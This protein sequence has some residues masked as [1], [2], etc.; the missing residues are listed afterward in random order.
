MKLTEPKPGADQRESKVLRLPP[1]E[2]TSE[3]ASAVVHSY[4]LLVAYMTSQMAPPFGQTQTKSHLIK[5]NY[6]FVK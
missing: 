2:P 6:V 4:A 5:E 1:T 3:R